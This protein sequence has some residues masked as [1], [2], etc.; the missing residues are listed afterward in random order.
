MT[1]RGVLLLLLVVS[2]LATAE[3]G[4][5]VLV[6]VASVTTETRA[7]KSWTLLA[8]RVEATTDLPLARLVP[9]ITDWAAYPRLFPKI[10]TLEATDGSVAFL[11][12]TT[13]VTVLGFSVRNRFTL[14]VVTTGTPPGPV[15]IHWTQEKTDGTI[16]ALEGGWELVPTGVGGSGTIIRYHTVSSVPEGF[17]GQAGV[18]GWFFPG[19][20]K[21]IVASVLAEARQ[22]KEKP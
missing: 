6:K 14:R 22:R 21:Q 18:V 8:G 16:E 1:L 15:S 20:L 2:G 11:T 9:V 7:G 10:K 5:R 12:E 17:P 19:E 4:D 13:E 3:T